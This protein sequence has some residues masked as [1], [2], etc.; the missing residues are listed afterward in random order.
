MTLTISICIVNL[1]FIID[2]IDSIEYNSKE[3]L[4]NLCI[5]NFQSYHLPQTLILTV[6]SHW[7]VTLFDSFPLLSYKFC[8]WV[9][10]LMPSFLVGL[11]NCV[12]SK[13]LSPYSLSSFLLLWH[14]FVFF[15]HVIIF[16]VSHFHSFLS[17]TSRP[18]SPFF[19]RHSFI[20]KVT[21][22]VSFL[23]TIL[24]NIS[25]MPA[26]NTFK[27]HAELVCKALKNFLTIHSLN[28]PGLV[29]TAMPA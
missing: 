24:V 12:G 26:E 1:G 17:L 7:L 25:T 16:H 11:F 4:N 3:K 20:Y 15:F 10:S 2:H 5:L 13:Y 19:S 9:S 29:N 28:A 6:L 14:P 23:L 27:K 21:I 8:F 18:S 22:S